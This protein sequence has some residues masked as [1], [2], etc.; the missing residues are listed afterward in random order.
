[1]MN[2]PPRLARWIIGAATERSERTWL[3]ADLDELYDARRQQRSRWRA[4]IWYR[5]Q[6]VR[7]IPPLLA[8]RL[9]PGRRK[10]KPIDPTS[11]S[12]HDA[13]QPE[14][15]NALLYD[16]R[17]AFRRLI[18]EPAFTIAAVLT[19]A[20][21]V[22][23]NVAVFA[24]VEAVLLRPLP[25][26]AADRVVILNH[27]D[28]RTGITKEFVPTA[29]YAELVQRQ[30]SFDALGAYGSGSTTIFGQG[31][32][33]R[34]R[35]FAA[36]QGAIVALGVRPTLGR[37][38]ETGDTRQGA[39]PI[40]ILSYEYWRDKL[41]SD[42][43][44][45]GRSLKMNQTM[46]TIVGVAPKGFRLRSTQP[47]DVILP[48][49]LPEQSA[50]R[51]E[52]FT[53]VIGR[54]KSG[55]TLQDAE[56]DL[57]R[58][59]RQLEREFPESNLAAS[60]FALSLRDVLVGSAKPALI[61]LLAAVGVVLVIACANVANLLLARSLARR[62]EMA[63]RMALG[64][65]RRRLAAQLLSESLALAVVAGLAGVLFAFWGARALV[66]L[67]PRSVEAAGLSDVHINGPV[68][69]FAL[70]LT[71]VTTL[72]FGFMALLTVRLDSA[73]SVLVGSGRTSSS[74]GVRRA[75]A[76]L[77][78]RSRAGSSASRWRGIDHAD[79]FR[80]AVGGSRLSIRSRDDDDDQHSRGPI[81]R[82]A[83][84]RRLLSKRIRC[85]A[86][87]PRRGGNRQCC[88]DTAHR[89]QLDGAIRTAGATHSSR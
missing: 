29:D 38:V 45:L 20:L 46:R 54:L 60:Y 84:A 21:G 36:T 70:G 43:K 67:V 13:R 22:G 32:P 61:L 65:G 82:H 41:G 18:G 57:T 4:D 12:E 83:C 44:V 30:T 2:R 72:A 85:T 86:R 35:V 31:E 81:S 33:Y 1:M 34:A 56:M 69:L 80:S 3:V 52:G 15:L 63:V 64:A 58:I 28:Q 62:R 23:G 14:T 74:G 47:A 11:T 50:R 55:L 76:G 37:L 51:R 75:A 68:L 49:I 5:W 79:V 88:R 42:P 8:R 25:Y 59:S 6:V 77:V 78:G 27:R 48:L 9:Q 26:A 24:V 87:R 19:L 7:S 66:A 53:F 71:A 39:A 17:H 16:L 73:A 40:V 10:L 89:E